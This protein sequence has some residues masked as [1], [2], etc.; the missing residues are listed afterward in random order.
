MLLFK[1]HLHSN[2]LRYNFI[3][4]TWSSVKCKGRLPKSRSEHS[5]LVH[6][7]S[8]F[9]FGGEINGD[10]CNEL[11]EFDFLSS[12]WTKICGG[13]KPFDISLPEIRTRSAFWVDGNKHQTCMWVAKW[14]RKYSQKINKSIF[15]YKKNF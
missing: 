1:I 7:D 5:A 13:K 15:V 14:M 4:Q 9:I 2:L 12:R 10:P 3:S 11:W 8:M 6:Q